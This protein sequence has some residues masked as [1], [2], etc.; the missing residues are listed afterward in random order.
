MKKIFIYQQFT[1]S[2]CENINTISACSCVRK[3]Q[4]LFQQGAEMLDSKVTL[5]LTSM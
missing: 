1:L 3:Y 5:M 4:W 2:N